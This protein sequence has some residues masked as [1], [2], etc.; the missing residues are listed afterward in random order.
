MEGKNRGG[1]GINEASKGVK[2][3]YCSNTQ[4]HTVNICQMIQSFK[5]QNKKHCE[6]VRASLSVWPAD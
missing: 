2:K 4:S 3:E 6:M 1:M 5:Q